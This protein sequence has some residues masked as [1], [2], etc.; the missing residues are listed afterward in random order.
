M[1]IVRLGETS[2]DPERRNSY[3]KD[4]EVESFIEHPD[5][6]PIT[7]YNDIALIKLRRNVLMSKN[8][9][10]ACLHQ[11]NYTNLTNQTVIAIGFGR[12]GFAEDYSEVL[13]KVNLTVIHPNLCLNTANGRKLQSQLCLKGKHIKSG[14]YGDACDGR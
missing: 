13:L 1:S 9:R 8:V 5:Y 4:Y 7:K 3:A 14:G 11:I 12:T 2:L 6:S 10:P